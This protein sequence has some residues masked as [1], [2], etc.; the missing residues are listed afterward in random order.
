MMAASSKFSPDYWGEIYQSGKFPHEYWDELG[1]SG[2]IGILIPTKWGG[3]N[4]T[5]MDYLLAVEETAH[6]F[7]G[8]ASYLYLSGSLVSM[9]IEKNGTDQ[10]KDD[11][12]PKFAK[13]KMKI[14]VALSEES[15][16]YNAA[17]IETV[18]TRLDDHYCEING[19]KAFV[20]NV[21]QADYLLVFARTSPPNEGS[22]SYGLSM[23]LVD[24][25]DPSIKATR[26]DKLGMDFI[27]TFSLYIKSLKVNYDQVMGEIDKGWY[28]IAENFMLDR[29]ATS[30]SLIGT[31]RL[32]LDTAV[33][34]AATRK[35]FGKIIGSNQGIQFPLADSF[36]KL[37]GAEALMFKA[38]SMVDHKQNFSQISNYAL[39]SSANAAIAAAESALRTFGG[40]GYLKSYHVERYWRDV[41]VHK[42]HPISEELLLASIAEKSLGL[43]KSY[44]F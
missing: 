42:I 25:K 11:L 29:I 31:G 8:I 38:G 27:G 14:S 16:G 17:A 37:E 34:H 35:V 39:H 22:R 21:D 3:M 12:L 7:A 26:L 33:K 1:K 20:N 5:F 6:H 32:A 10:Q 44:N 23:F 40:H 9:V 15:A 36:A 28:N 18:A 19:T 2:L 30:A 41:K 13:G 4:R 24:P 43:P